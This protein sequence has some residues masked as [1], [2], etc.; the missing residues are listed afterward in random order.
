MSFYDTVPYLLVVVICL[1]S[2]I[3]GISPRRRAQDE[4]DEEGGQQ[5][6]WRV[7]DT[8]PWHVTRKKE[9]G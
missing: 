9:A 5:A 7:N 4:R 6:A 2:L 8:K 3:V 1:F